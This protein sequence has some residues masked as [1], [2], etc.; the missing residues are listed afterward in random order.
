MTGAAVGGFAGLFISVPAILLGSVFGAA[1]AERW[2]GQRGTEQALRAGLAAGLGFLVAIFL[3]VLLAFAMLLVFA[4]D[5]WIG[6]D[7]Q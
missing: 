4:L 3:R 1:L 6:P 7:V 2:L 5:C